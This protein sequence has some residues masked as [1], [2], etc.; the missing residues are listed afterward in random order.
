MIEINLL[1]EHLRKKKKTQ[2]ISTATLN[3]PM[4]AIVGLLGGFLV[5]MIVVDLGFLGFTLYKYAQHGKLKKDWEQFQP[6]KQNVDRVV[7]DLRALQTKLK[8][9]EGITT[10]KRILWSIK[11]NEISNNLPKEIWLNKI[12]FED[13]SLVIDGSAVSKNQDEM[14]SVESFTA[15]LR[16]QEGFMKD[17]ASLEVGVIQ[18][19]KIQATEL[20]DFSINV[21]LR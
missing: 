17:V 1:P 14:L 7:N 5:L 18:R 15:N 21:K 3:L 19:R 6:E 20:A 10:A 12:T 16:S 11:L 13:K 4:E 2:V 9:V 8:S